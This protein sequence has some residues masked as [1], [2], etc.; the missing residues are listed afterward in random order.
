[1]ERGD[2]RFIPRYE[3]VYREVLER[4]HNDFRAEGLHSYEYKMK[5]KR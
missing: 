2:D 4:Y 1:M 5:S 3:E